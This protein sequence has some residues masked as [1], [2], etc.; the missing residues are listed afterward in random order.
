MNGT[1][2]RPKN[3]YDFKHI[4]VVGH[5]NFLRSAPLDAEESQPQHCQVFLEFLQHF[6][7]YSDFLEYAQHGPSSI[8][9][10]RFIK[11]IKKCD[12][13]PVKP[14]TP[15]WYLGLDFTYKMLEPIIGNKKMM[16]HIDYNGDTACGI[17]YNK[18]KCPITG[19]PFSTKGSLVGSPIWQDELHRFHVALWQVFGKKEYLP[20]AELLD[21]KLRTVY[22]GETPFVFWQKHMFDASDEALKSQN[23]NY[24]ACWSRYGHVKQYGGTNRLARAHNKFKNLFPNKS[25]EFFIHYT[26]DISGWDRLLPILTDVYDMRKRLYGTMDTFEEFVFNYIKEGVC[27]PYCVLPDGT[28][29]QKEIGNVSG[30]GKTTT[31]NTI[32]HIMIE[33]YHFIRLF[34]RKY[35]IMPKYYDILFAVLNSLYGDDSLTSTFL[36]FWLTDEELRDGP[37]AAAEIYFEHY[38]NSYAQFGLTVKKSQFKYKFGTVDDLEFLGVT[39]TK[40]NF[41]DV[42]GGEPRYSKI[43]TTLTQTLETSSREPMAYASVC[44]AVCTLS[45]GLSDKYALRLQS[46]IPKYATFILNKFNDSLPDSVCFDLAKIARGE[47]HANKIAFGFESAPV[48]FNDKKFFFFPQCKTPRDRVGFKREMNSTNNKNTFTE[49]AAAAS[50]YFSNDNPIFKSYNPQFNYVGEV[51]DFMAKNRLFGLT[52]MFA[53]EGP[54]HCLRWSGTLCLNE[55]PLIIVDD[56]PT[57]QDAKNKLHY[58]IIK[59]IL[60]NKPRTDRINAMQNRPSPQ[61]MFLSSPPTGEA[62]PSISRSPYSGFPPEKVST[63]SNPPP[64]TSHPMIPPQGEGTSHPALQRGEEV[65]IQM[66]CLSFMQCLRSYLKMPADVQKYHAMHGFL[67]LDDVTAAAR[68]AD[69]F[70]EGGF[71]PYGNGQTVDSKYI[72]LFRINHTVLSDGTIEITS[73]VQYDDAPPGVMRGVGPDIN[74]AF[75]EWALQVED[76]LA[77]WDPSPVS[78]FLTALQTLPNPGGSLSF[79]WSK[80]AQHMFAKIAGIT[81]SHLRC[82]EED[83]CKPARLRAVPDI[84]GAQRYVSITK[85]TFY[86]NSALEACAS[87]VISIDGSNPT[88]FTTDGTSSIDQAF[89]SLVSSMYDMISQW[90]P[91]TPLVNL[92]HIIRTKM[93]PPPSDH[94]LASVWTSDVDHTVTMIKAGSFNPYGNGQPGSPMSFAEYT[95]R[96][97][98]SFQGMSAK[99]IADRYKSYVKLTKTNNHKPKPLTTVK[100]DNHNKIAPSKND[101]YRQNRSRIGTANVPTRATYDAARKNMMPKLSS[102]ARIYYAALVCPFYKLD[103]SCKPLLRSLKIDMYE[104]ENPCI[105]SELCEK[106]QKFSCFLRDQFMV[107]SNAATVPGQAFI[108]FAPRRLANDAV[109]TTYNTCAVYLSTAA[110]NAGIGAPYPLLEVAGPVDTGVIG[111]NLNSIY[112]SASLP[113]VAGKGIK[114]RVVAAGLRVRYIGAESLRA[115][116]IHACATPIHDTLSS[117]TSA[118]IGAFETSFRMGVTRDWVTVFH[119]P[120]MEDD[121]KY[122]PDS[123]QNP[124]FFGD[125]FSTESYQHYLGIQITDCPGGAFEY[126]VICHYECTGQLVR[127]QTPTPSDT[128]GMSAVM[129]A[130]TT[131]SM[132]EIN[133][134]AQAGQDL[135]K[136][137]LEGTSFVSGLV[138]SVEKILPLAALV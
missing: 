29:I 62:G 57:K 21:D 114:Y 59:L 30:S 51:N 55:L 41:P 102:C 72:N 127:G 35:G 32:A 53:H 50:R 87:V 73:T 107:S 48:V 43:F 2:R 52:F 129:N 66:A 56:M 85:P 31:D 5:S 97:K 132:P 16:A 63:T 122:Y 126:E 82:D 4:K 17:P 60:D 103:E 14:N 38:F 94:V 6:P 138:S 76:K 95:K 12:A 136:P 96:N 88:P 137:L 99:A 89:L 110:W 58:E 11:S 75:A 119:I 74:S 116:I 22:C 36:D 121:L 104:S 84:T 111:Q 128:T 69:C 46:F 37:Q 101:I 83:C 67:Q 112:N 68:M 92:I 106:S 49:F 44:A 93:P 9:E 20:V 123:I 26:A 124:S 42:Y 3:I 81:P 71:N 134:L 39:F 45:C 98:K 34:V 70:K 61:E 100:A 78:P 109:K 13:P 133:K 135:G 1:I 8:T 80:D 47:Y 115:G 15:E 90:E 113:L 64:V 24:R 77:I 27:F 120:V 7:E 86:I 40:T 105:P 28:I 33:F 118:G 117:A 125:Y 131:A 23:E 130:A 25:D 10:K 65:K 108:A 79:L 18:L 91:E 19:L 54:Q